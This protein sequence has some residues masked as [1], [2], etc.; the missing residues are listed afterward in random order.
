VRI[1]ALALIVAQV[2]PCRK[3]I[4]NRYFEHASLSGSA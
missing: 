2:M 3:R 1:L 4:V